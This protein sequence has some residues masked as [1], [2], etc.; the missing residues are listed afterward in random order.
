MV[1]RWFDL[2]TTKMGLVIWV[3][4]SLWRFLGLGLKIDGCGLVIWATKLPRRFLG[5]DL[6]TKWVML[7]RLCLKI[8]GMM[9]TARD[10]HRD[11]AACFTW[12]RVGLGFS[13]LASRLA[14]ARHGWECAIITEVTWKWSKR[15][16]VQ[17]RRV[18]RNSSRTKLPLPY[19]N[20][21][22]SP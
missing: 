22:F 20:F 18:R 5:L 15:Q 10:T 13:C 11:L 8:D 6:K 17:W 4:K 7:C 12:K 14:E 2:K 9:K 21:L 16:S 19:C 3:S 1:C